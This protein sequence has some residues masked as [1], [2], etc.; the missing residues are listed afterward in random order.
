MPARNE[1]V[2]GTTH[3]H[4]LPF[5]NIGGCPHLFFRRLPVEISWFQHFILRRF[6][7][8]RS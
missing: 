8:R 6:A 4:L 3:P 5:R 1:S 7:F 2:I